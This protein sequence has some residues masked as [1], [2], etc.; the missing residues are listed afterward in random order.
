MFND[1]NYGSD[2]IY[3]SQGFDDSLFPD[4]L[5]SPSF[6]EIFLDDY[7]KRFTSLTDDVEDEVEKERLEYLARAARKLRK[8]RKNYEKHLADVDIYNEYMQ[9]LADK[10]GGWSI[11]RNCIMEDAIDDY[12]PSKPQ[13]RANRYTKMLLKAGLVPLTKAAEPDFSNFWENYDLMY[14][15]PEELREEEMHKKLKKKERA[16]IKRAFESYYK[17]ER[18]TGLIKDMKY[19]PG[20]DFIVEYYSQ[21]SKGRYDTTRDD[22]YSM[23]FVERMKEERLNECLPDV[24]KDRENQGMYAISNARLVSREQTEQMEILDA[25]YS[26]G[27]DIFSGKRSGMNKAA[28]KFMKKKYGIEKP[29][30]DKELKKWNKKQKKREAEI[31]SRDNEIARL[32]TGNKWTCEN[33][34]DQISFTLKDLKRD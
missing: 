12:I 33:L 29:M 4:F 20:F 14:G 32:L 7:E 28:V 26:Q 18:R 21:A 9:A 23:G 24:F 17:E 11:L 22:K 8:K 19:N 1:Q 30:T 6:N 10:Y 15:K 34:N 3:D 25:L 2:M 13:L 16:E 5:F 31:R 27:Y